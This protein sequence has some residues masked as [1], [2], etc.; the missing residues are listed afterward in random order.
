[1][2]Q[3]GGACA[4]AIL[5]Y[6]AECRRGG[7]FYRWEGENAARKTPQPAEE[8][9]QRRMLLLYAY[10][11]DCSNIEGNLDT[12]EMK[13]YACWEYDLDEMAGRSG[14]GAAGMPF[15]KVQDA[16]SDCAFHFLDEITAQVERV[17][18]AQ[19]ALAFREGAWYDEARN[20]IQ[21]ITCTIADYIREEFLGMLPPQWIRRITRQMFV[22]FVE[23]YLAAC[24]ELLGDVL[25]KPKKKIV[26]DWRAFRTCLV[27]DAELAMGMWERCNVDRQLVELAR[28]ALEL[29]KNL[30]SVKKLTDFRFFLQEQL[31]D[32]FGDCPTFVIRFTLQARPDE[33]DAETMKRMLATWRELIAHQKRDPKIDLPTAGWSQSTSFYGSI[34][35]SIAELGKA[36]GLF[37]K[38]AKKK[39]QEQRMLK[40][41]AEKKASRE[42]Y[43]AQS[44]PSTTE[45]SKSRTPKLNLMRD[46]KIVQVA[47]L[48][49]ILK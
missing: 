9:Q 4:E 29:L 30:L 18:G 36:T 44:S 37:G 38:S 40:E 22:R 14:D 39:R 3:I 31:L 26:K 49:D 12:I 46:A 21:V 7:D 35:R 41:E 25:R 23:R 45:S 15:L 27:R 34:D 10:V 8:W 13:F 2:R 47:A 33:I 42:A 5:S 16:L 19:W 20:P 17:V 11:N 28:K 24:M 43:K 1:M 6:L 48:S 32:D